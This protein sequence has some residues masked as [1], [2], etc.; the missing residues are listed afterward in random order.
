MLEYPYMAQEKTHPTIGMVFGVFD[1]LHPGHRY[2]LDA[3]SKQCETLV[4]VVALS[5]IVMLI[6]K[7]APRFD[8][9]ERVK[10]IQNFNPKLSVVPSDKTI[11][12]WEVF[13]KYSPD[14]VFLG[15]DQTALACA[16]DNTQMPYVILDAH[17]PEKFKSSILHKSTLEK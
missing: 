13:K 3:A 16:L 9:D 7:H 4:V 14:V 6:K 8:F 17:H 2:F 15:H 11:G 10:C 1:G 5:E 12:T